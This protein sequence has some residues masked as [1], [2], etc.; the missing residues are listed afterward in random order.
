[1]CQQKYDIHVFLLTRHLKR[2]HLRSD[3]VMICLNDRQVKKQ[4]AQN[5]NGIQDDQANNNNLINKI[6]VHGYFQ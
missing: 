3:S 6:T 4:L 2:T 1:M 5:E